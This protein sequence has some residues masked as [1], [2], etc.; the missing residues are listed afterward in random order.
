ML[1]GQR[2][3]QV[4]KSSAL[5]SLTSRCTNVSRAASESDSAPYT[6]ATP[7]ELQRPPYN[8]APRPENASRG[9]REYRAGVRRQTSTEWLSAEDAVLDPP[10][11]VHHAG[12]A[13]GGVEQ[14][15]WSGTP[16]GSRGL[17]EP[18]ASIL[19]PQHG[20]RLCQR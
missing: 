10:Q 9:V 13:V 17:S 11:L 14:R 2:A 19:P 16:K 7:L 15:E 18:V 20:I 5:V 6:T 12:K 3:T 4:M 8:R 1:S